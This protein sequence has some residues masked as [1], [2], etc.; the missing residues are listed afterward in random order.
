M[1]WELNISDEALN[2]ISN[3]V[4]WYDKIRIGLLD[5]FILNLEVVIQRISQNP[6]LFA[7]RERKCRFAPLQRFP[8]SV[9]Y[10]EEK[11]VVNIIGVIHQRRNPEI[12]S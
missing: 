2:D 8:F 4:D 5:D 6:F 9:L 3:A 12:F 11:Y 10:S 1:V 7:V